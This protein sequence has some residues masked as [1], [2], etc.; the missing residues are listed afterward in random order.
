[1]GQRDP[2]RDGTAHEHEAEADAD[3]RQDYAAQAKC[4]RVGQR[5]AKEHCPTCALKTP[6]FPQL[7]HELAC[8]S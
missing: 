5:Y 1:M 7:H 3:I 2:H 6:Q 8:H 4:H